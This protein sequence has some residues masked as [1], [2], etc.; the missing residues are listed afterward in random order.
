MR[1]ARAAGIF[2][3][4]T[5][6][7][8]L[9]VS[10]LSFTLVRLSPID[11]VQAYVGNDASVS[12]EQR[13]RIA[14]RWGLREPPVTQYFTWLG[15]L[16]RGDFGESTLFR[17]PVLQ[18]IRERAVLSAALMALSWAFSGLL[19][20]ALGVVAGAYRGGWP[21]RAI[22]TWCLVLASA[23][24]FW[25]AMALMLAFAVAF[26]VLPLGLAAPAGKLA[27]DITFADRARH[28]VLPC[29]AL[30]LSGISSMA[31]QTRQ[32][33]CEALEQDYALYAAARGESKWTI[34]FRHGIRNIALP[35]LTIQFL[36]FSELFGGSVLAEQ[37]FSYP[38]LGRTV[39]MA[40]M[41]SDIPLL[42]G[43]TIFSAFFVFAGN[44]AANGLY[45]LVNPEI[46]DR[47]L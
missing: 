1:W 11:P 14:R 47:E 29:A 34:I 12:N 9:A 41:K 44:T 22:K 46:K 19:G 31:M 28:L 32:K 27:A 33:L 21:D 7:L 37:V 10:A 6:A 20:F 40:G 42:L 3:A 35:A 17:L 8:F 16:C 2:A 25:L 23:P 15:N 4:K 45:R 13:E 30:T 38:G 5:L 18:V 26:P 39:V 36:S 24:T 43:I